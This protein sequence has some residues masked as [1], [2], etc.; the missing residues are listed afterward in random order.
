MSRLLDTL[1]PPERLQPA[2]ADIYEPHCVMQWREQ[3]AAM[4]ETGGLHTPTPK[5]S[6]AACTS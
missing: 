4:D 2:P 3:M 6:E 5:S 1:L